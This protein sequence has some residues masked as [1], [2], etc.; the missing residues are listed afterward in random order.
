MQEKHAL[1]FSEVTV[2]EASLLCS[3]PI[4]QEKS[5]HYPHRVCSQIAEVTVYQPIIPTNTQFTFEFMQ[6][7]LPYKI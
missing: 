4:S 6:G 5:S 7:I 3:K 1:V 2:F